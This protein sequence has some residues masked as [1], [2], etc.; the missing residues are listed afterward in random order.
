[1]KFTKLLTLI[2]AALLLVSCSNE[3]N[4][5]NSDGSQCEIA[6]EVTIQTNNDSWKSEFSGGTGFVDADMTD[7]SKNRGRL[8]TYF[9]SA[10]VESLE[11]SGAITSLNYGEMDPSDNKKQLGV[12]LAIGGGSKVGTFTLNFEVA[13]IS[14]TVY[15]LS[16]Y[17]KYKT[18]E[19][20]PNNG[21]SKDKNSQLIIT[22]GTDFE[23][24]DLRDTSEMEVK[25]VSLT[26][27]ESK[28][29]VFQNKSA[30]AGRVIIDKIVFTYPASC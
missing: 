30:T 27:I 25:T 12:G 13:P 28:Q 9:S 22:A 24:L 17:K 6:Q 3:S 2:S 14:V 15:A 29:L 1:M 4:K 19:G 18:Y 26:D 10:H 16:Y 21:L 20:D 5:K 23:T 8:L 11:C 7:N